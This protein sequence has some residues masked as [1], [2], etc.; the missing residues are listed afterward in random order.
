[1]ILALLY[2]SQ[3][4]GLDCPIVTCELEQYRSLVPDW[5]LS[6]VTPP[7]VLTSQLSTMLQAEGCAQLPMTS[8]G[9]FSMDVGLKLLQE[10]ANYTILESW[11][12]DK[13]PGAWLGPFNFTGTVLLLC[14][15]FL[16]HLL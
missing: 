16:V 11:R 9:W 4:E 14:V 10:G 13:I 5:V 6:P 1:V 12:E 8:D 3:L 7:P 2:S 15:G